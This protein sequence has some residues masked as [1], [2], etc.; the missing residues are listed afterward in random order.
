[1]TLVIEGAPR[2]KKTSNRILRFG[3]FNKIVPSEAYLAWR[4]AAVPQLREQGRLVSWARPV[5]VR[6]VV[7]RDANRGD[8]IGYLQ[9]L[10]DALQE[11]GVIVDDKFIT[12][13][14]LSRL[15]K[16]AVRPRIEIEITP[17]EPNT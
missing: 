9:G 1:M 13:W 7:Y 12:G 6:A 16:D 11:A 2:T 15:A 8:L 4:D 10:A 17:M 14:D 5:N 3:R